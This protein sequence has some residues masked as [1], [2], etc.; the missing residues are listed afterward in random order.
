MRLVFRVPTKTFDQDTLDAQ[1][2][3]PS[4]NDTEGVPK[5]SS[6]SRVKCGKISVQGKAM[7]VVTIQV[8]R[9]AEIA[10]PAFRIFLMEASLAYLGSA[11]PKG[12]KKS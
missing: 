9:K 1:L 12:S 7:Q 8:F 5:Y 6:E 10:T 11:K 3:I 2:E 4:L